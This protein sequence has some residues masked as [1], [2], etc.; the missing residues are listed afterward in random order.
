MQPKPTLSPVVLERSTFFVTQQPEVLKTSTNGR[1][2]TFLERLGVATLPIVPSSGSEEEDSREK[3][4][5]KSLGS[6]EQSNLRN[7]E[8]LPERSEE[9]HSA[10]E[11]EE[12][13]EPNSTSIPTTEEQPSTLE[14]SVMEK[15]EIAS[16]EIFG[17]SVLSVSSVSPLATTEVSTETTTSEAIIETETPI[18]TEETT[19]AATTIETTTEATTETTTTEVT[20]VHAPTTTTSAIITTKDI[21]PVT[22]LAF[23]EVTDEI[24]SS[25]SSNTTESTVD[26][27][28]TDVTGE[29]SGLVPTDDGR[30]TFSTGIVGLRSPPLPKTT[31][32]EKVGL[33]VVEWTDTD[34][35]V[36]KVLTQ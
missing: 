33:E 16:S 19:K 25:A 6:E 7:G 8:F 12:N 23:Q 21:K 13:T 36:R 14:P 34:N 11:K 3:D 29:G 32:P 17:T 9:G 27:R 22:L 35:E 10:E 2:P 24:V 1:H 4:I 20:T 5:L 30:S 18:T 15:D 26:Q 28:T 31:D